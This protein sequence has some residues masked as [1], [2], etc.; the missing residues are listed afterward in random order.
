MADIVL[1][2]KPKWL[3]LI[4]SGKKTAEVR[5]CLPKKL[6]PGDKIY[7]YCKGDIHGV[8]VVQEVERV[9]DFYHKR[10]IINE[11]AHDAC[12]H[13]KDIWDYWFLASSP[14]VILLQDVERFD[15]PHPWRGAVPQNFIYYK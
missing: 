1:A 6:E 11:Y 12:L 7:L 9:T 14:G 3:E 15:D 10:A 13:P 5:R 8:A 4:L 2:L